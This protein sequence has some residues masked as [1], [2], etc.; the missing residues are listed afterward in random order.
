MTLEPA[1]LA[2]LQQMDGRRTIREIMA[3]ASPSGVLPQPSQADLEQFATTLFQSLWQ[4]DF[5][6]MGLK[7]G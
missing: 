5:L 6:A 3:A 4:L 1:Q 2:L 7:R